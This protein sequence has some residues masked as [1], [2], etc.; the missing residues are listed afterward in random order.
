MIINGYDTLVGSKFK[1]T[2]RI[3]ST[4]KS[5]ATTNR[6]TKLDSTPH[7]VYMITNE[8]SDNIPSFAF[9]ITLKDYRGKS[10]TVFD[11][12]NYVNSSGKVV[13]EPE[14][15]MIEVASALQQLAGINDKAILL[16][17]E[18]YT[19]KAFARSIGNIL[20]NQANLDFSKKLEL[21]II[22]A[23]Y[24]NCLLTNSSD[25]YAFVSQNVL[26]RSLG[27][28]PSTTVPIIE[29]VGYI[30]TLEDLVNT[31]KNSP[32]LPTLNRITVVELLSIINRT[33]FVSSGFK[34]IIGVAAELPHLFTAICFASITNNI[35]RKTE[36]GKILDIKNNSNIG[37]FIKSINN[38]VYS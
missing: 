13:N 30:N 18:T 24:F 9:P 33:W 38:V 20:A 37:E 26:K 25:D 15:N 19:V 34:M 8:N 27:Y 3:E 28:N 14:L 11:Q 22:L 1:V 16:S 5:L 31:L 10:I 23:H 7:E 12:R 29:E 2:D 21:E 35:Y 32:R 36:I 6:L 17:S 4:I